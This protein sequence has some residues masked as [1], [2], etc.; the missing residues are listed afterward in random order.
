MENIYI[1]KIREGYSLIGKRGIEGEKRR[2]REERGRERERRRVAEIVILLSTLPFAYRSTVNISLP[3]L[4]F[5]S[6]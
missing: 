5:F 4:S 3:L 2:G 1:Y 6:I